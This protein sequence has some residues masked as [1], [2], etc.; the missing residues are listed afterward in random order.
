MN[1]ERCGLDIAKRV[2]QVHGVDERGMTRERRM[3]KRS[4]VLGYF[5]ALSPCLIGMEACAGAHYWARELSKFGHTI[6][7]MAAQFVNPYRKSGKNDANDAEAICEAVGRPNM[8]FVA[9]KTEEQQAVLTWHRARVL[10]VAGR[11]AQVNQIRGLL[12]EFGLVVPQGIAR[13]RRQLPQ[14]LEDAENGLPDL[15]RELLNELL[16]QLRQGDEQISRYDR[17]IAHLASLS[18]AAGRLMAI[19]GVGPVTATAIIASV[20]DA[21]VFANGRQFAAWIGLTPRQHSSGGRSRLGQISKRGDRYLRTLLVH[22]SRALLRYVARKQDP[23]S[24]WAARLMQRRHVNVA[25]VAL[26]AKQARIIWAMLA[27][28]TEYRAAPIQSVAV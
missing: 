1:L 8:R 16:G 14:I 15:A 6:R 4:Q 19:D 26:A 7:L 22:G 23:K 2:F 9:A 21:K 25:A 27:K 3:L 10:A 11:T 20:G 18:E 28:G 24:A 13:L 12:G 17:Q 5:A